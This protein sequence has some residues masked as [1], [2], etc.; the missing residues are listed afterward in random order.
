ME[1]LRGDVEKACKTC[2]T[3][4]LSKGKS[5]KYRKIPIKD[6]E[7]EPWEILCVDLIGPYS[8]KNINYKKYLINIIK[9]IILKIVK[10]NII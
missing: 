9:Q 5:I 3:C 8:I 1:N 4:Q 6:V 10:Y 7:V 2:K